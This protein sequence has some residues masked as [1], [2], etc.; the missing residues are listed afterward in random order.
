MSV[1]KKVMCLIQWAVSGH[2]ANF[3]CAIKGKYTVLCLVLFVLG[4]GWKCL[5][6]DIFFED[7]ESGLPPLQRFPHCSAEGSKP[8][9]FG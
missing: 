4:Y 9:R 3:Q 8:W 7:R 2:W 1:L 5:D 6:F